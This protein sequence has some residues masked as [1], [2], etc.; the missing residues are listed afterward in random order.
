MAFIVVLYATFFYWKLAGTL[1]VEF[2]NHMAFYSRFYAT[3]ALLKIEHAVI[4]DFFY[5]DFTW[6]AVVSMW[7]AMQRDFYID[8]SLVSHLTM[9]SLPLPLQKVLEGEAEA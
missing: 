9:L 5:A 4:R 8:L 6:L 7:F 1:N 3:F 2:W